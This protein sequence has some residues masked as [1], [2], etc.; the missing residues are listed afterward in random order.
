MAGEE[1]VPTR[2]RL[3]EAAVAVMAESGWS[4]VT[5]R[6]VAERAR[7][8]NA[9]VHYYFGSVDALRKAAVMHAVE[10]ELE[11]PVEA[12][13]QAEDVLDGVAEA[14]DGLV[15]RG[16]GTPQ[17]RVVV[18]ALMQGLRDEEL[19]EAGIQQ[20]RAF[21]DLLAA[22]LA[23]GRDAGLLRADADPAGLAV[24]L[25]ALLDGLL[26]HVLIDPGTDAATATRGLLALLRPAGTGGSPG[27]G[28]RGDDD[29]DAS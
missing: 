5:S 11:G 26:L 9:L 3:L 21:R 13:L 7:A 4:A 12:I 6:V 25:G 29:D 19:R 16:P 10:K 18:E 17:Q 2:I 8:N 27:P 28:Q 22:R 1:Q 20:I 14:I 24:V 15:E 23:A